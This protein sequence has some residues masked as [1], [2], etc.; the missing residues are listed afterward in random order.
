MKNPLYALMPDPAL[1]YDDRKSL[2][3]FVRHL[4]RLRSRIAHTPEPSDDEQV[5]LFIL[6]KSIGHLRG[7]IQG[8]GPV[9]DPPNPTPHAGTAD[10]PPCHRNSLTTF[11]AEEGMEFERAYGTTTSRNLKDLRTHFERLRESVVADFG[12]HSVP[13]HILATAISEMTSRVRQILSMLKKREK[14]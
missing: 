5:A 14:A 1:N 11:I 3:N 2:S 7:H 4:E 12:E 13:S 6:D 10:G 8:K 9:A